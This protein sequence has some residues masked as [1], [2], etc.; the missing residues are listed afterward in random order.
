MSPVRIIEVVAR[1]IGR[2]LAEHPHQPPLVQVVL[3]LIER[4]ISQSVAV[5]RSIEDQVDGV[6]D[7]R[8]STCTRTSRPPRFSRQLLSVPEVGNRRLMAR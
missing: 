8:S 1:K 4:E 2:E 3:N 6:K 5:E 7:Q